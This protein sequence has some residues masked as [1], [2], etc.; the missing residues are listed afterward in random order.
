MSCGFFIR[1]PFFG[2]SN[3]EAQASP[4]C[5]PHG[6]GLSTRSSRRLCLT[7]E[8]AVYKP[9]EWSTYMNATTT[10]TQPQAEKF[11]AGIASYLSDDLDLYV[12][13]EVDDMRLHRL[14]MTL[15]AL[16]W[17]YG[18][19]GNAARPVT[20]PHEA[21][22]EVPSANMECMMLLLSDYVGDVKP[23]SYRAV[24]SARETLLKKPA[25]DLT[26]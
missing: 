17:M 14:K 4:V 12:I 13:T 3:G 22:I 23:V 6:P 2:G 5:A 19:V 10:T 25:D 7:A 1:A 8:A 18:A 15:E 11:H 21:N 26:H 20:E 9:T 24:T 16:G